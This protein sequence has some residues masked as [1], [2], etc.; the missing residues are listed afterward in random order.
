MGFNAHLSSGK[1]IGNC[2]YYKFLSIEKVLDDILHCVLSYV[3]LISLI[4]VDIYL[5]RVNKQ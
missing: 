3:A 5:L 2:E 1:M 4:P